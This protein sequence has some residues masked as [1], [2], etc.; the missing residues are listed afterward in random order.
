MGML[1]WIAVATALVLVWALFVRP[2]LRVQPRA[3]WFFDWIEPLE[4]RLYLKSE[5]ILVARFPQFLGLLLTL[6]GA[7]GGIDYSAITPLLPEFWRAFVPAFP[8]LLNVLG[9]ILEKLR[10]DIT[11]P[12]AEVART[13]PANVEGA[14]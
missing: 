12:L 1:F 13:E 6:I 14:L 10:R 4:R 9:T 7:L 5:M 2:V 3:K 8:L 11:K